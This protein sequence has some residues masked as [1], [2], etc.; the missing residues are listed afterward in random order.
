LGK[1]K[2]IGVVK[3]VSLQTSIGRREVLQENKERK[4]NGRREK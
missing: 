2:G 4:L 1:T 3:K